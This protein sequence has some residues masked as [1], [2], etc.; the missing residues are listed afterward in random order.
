MLGYKKILWSSLLYLAMMLG[1]FFQ[2][3]AATAEVFQA[4]IPDHIE[5]AFFYY[6]I[7]VM[8]LGQFVAKNICLFW[9]ANRVRY[10]AE[11]DLEVNNL[12]YRAI[13]MISEKLDR[14]RDHK[15]FTTLLQQALINTARK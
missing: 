14:Y 13:P 9:K 6:C 3:A 1:G 15:E 11:Y 12:I 4:S 2:F 7:V 8:L 10:N 5:T